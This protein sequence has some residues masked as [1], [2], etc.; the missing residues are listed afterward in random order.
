MLD[1]LLRLMLRI[2]PHGPAFV[3]CARSSQQYSSATQAFLGMSLIKRTAE[4]DS[5][6]STPYQKLLNSTGD[7]A[8]TSSTLMTWLGL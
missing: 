1:L 3:A 2:A 8:A 7:S 5:E 6:T 4:G